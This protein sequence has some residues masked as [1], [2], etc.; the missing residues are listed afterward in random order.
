MKKPE[1]TIE[2]GIETQQRQLKQWEKVLKPEIYAELVRLINEKTER[3]KNTYTDGY[4]VFRGVNID[5]AIQNWFILNN[6]WNK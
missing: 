1:F 6:D 5:S 3:E 2:Q 4:N